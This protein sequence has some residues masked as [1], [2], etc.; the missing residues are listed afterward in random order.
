VPFNDS[1][2]LELAEA[3]NEEGSRDARQSPLEFIEVTAPE[4]Q[5]A[6]DE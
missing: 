4:Q 1:V 5:L 6:Y 2:V 3:R